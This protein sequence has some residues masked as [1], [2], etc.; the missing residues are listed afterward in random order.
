MRNK[1]TLRGLTEITQSFQR[2]VVSLSLILAAFVVQGV[3][4]IRA[5][6]VIGVTSAFSN[7]IKLAQ[8]EDSS[9]S[10]NVPKSAAAKLNSTNKSDKVSPKKKIAVP[11]NKDKAGVR[12]LPDNLKEVV[13]FAVANHPQVAITRA[14]LGEAKAGIIVTEANTGFQLDGSLATGYGAQSTNTIPLGNELFQQPN[15]GNGKRYVLSLSGKKLLYDFGTSDK[16]ISRAMKLA[17]AEEFNLSARMNDIGQA[18]A[19]AYLNVVETRDLARLNKNNIVALEEI[20]QLVQLNQTNGNGTVADVKRVEA[21]LVD[22]RAVAADNEAELQNALDRFQRLVKAEPGDL[23]PVPDLADYTPAKVESAIALLPQTSPR[24]RAGELSR[25]AAE[26]ELEAKK[27]SLL[28]QVVFQTDSTLKSYTGSYW[29]NFDAQAMVSMTYKFMDGGLS[30]GQI[31]QLLARLEQD[32][33]GYN[34]DRDEAEADLRKF[35]TTIASA[36]SKTA[37]LADGVDASLKARGLYKEQFQGG[38][39]TLFEL[40]DIQTAAF[41]AERALIMNMFEERRAVYGVLSTM[42]VFIEAV[43]GERNAMVAEETMKSKEKTKQKI[44]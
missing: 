7:G 42:G 25:R 41:N 23:K 3:L 27:S 34:F 1:C 36:R 24:L 21:R 9:A 17:S 16:N 28:P 26:L 30:Q 8:T 33:Q 5:E 20:Q 19:Q 13:A 44:Q 2:F 35:Y 11:K 18:M 38:K 40:L 10:D 39:R 43:N 37:S 4:P 29:N 15:L 14:R 32:E 6:E 12:A 31:G 22:A